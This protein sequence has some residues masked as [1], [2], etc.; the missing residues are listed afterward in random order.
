M[1]PVFQSQKPLSKPRRNNLRRGELCESR[2]IRT[3]PSIELAACGSSGPGM[4]SFGAWESEVLEHVY[5]HVEYVSLQLRPGKK[6]KARA[7]CPQLP[8]T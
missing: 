5:D 2:R 6:G 8:G 7:G 4:S 1:Y 3:D